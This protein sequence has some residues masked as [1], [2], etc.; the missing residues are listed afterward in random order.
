MKMVIDSSILIDYIRGGSKWEEFVQEVSADTEF[1]LPTIVIYEL[2]AGA[3]TK[4]LKHS[5]EL[6]DFLK[7]FEK[8]DLTEQIAKRAGELFRDLSQKIEIPDYIIAASALEIGGAVV[9]LNQ[10]HF[11]QIPQLKLY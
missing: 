10:K 4:S 7:R 2:F 9:T 5:Q 8:I 6:T 1:Y 3:S 11:A